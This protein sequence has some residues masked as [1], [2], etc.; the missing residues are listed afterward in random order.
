[1]HN[2]YPFKTFLYS[3]IISYI[4]K[5]VNKIS[6]FSTS[7]SFTTIKSIRTYIN[8]R[9]KVLPLGI[10]SVLIWLTL[11][12]CGILETDIIH[13]LITMNRDSSAK[14]LEQ[15]TSFTKE[16]SWHPSLPQQQIR[17]FS[18]NKYGK[19]DIQICWRSHPVSCSE[20]SWGTSPFV[21]P[22]D[23]LTLTTHDPILPRLR[24]RVAVL[25]FPHVPSRCTEKLHLYFTP[26]AASFMYATTSV[27]STDQEMVSAMIAMDA[28]AQRFAVNEKLLLSMLT[29]FAQ[30]TRSL[31][32]IRNVGYFQSVC[33][34]KTACISCQ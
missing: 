28:H 5:I 12:H 21:L 30:C 17:L 24:L 1:M 27:L 23:G 6:G 33:S 31:H 32:A 11:Q 14:H 18:K 20:H 19:W 16:K 4:I 22:P 15:A 8:I 13:T 9:V 34:N 25:Q 7:D 2:S 10:A 29:A 3:R 26:F